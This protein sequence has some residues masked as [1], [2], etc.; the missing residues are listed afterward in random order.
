MPSRFW[1]IIKTKCADK[2]NIEVLH[3]YIT[4]NCMQ[5]LSDRVSFLQLQNWLVQ[6]CFL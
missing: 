4:L 5:I 3:M 2:Q 6:V 1:D